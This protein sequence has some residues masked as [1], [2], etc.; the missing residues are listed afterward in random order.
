MISEHPKDQANEI[1]GKC[2]NINFA[3]RAA[4]YFL[5]SKKIALETVLATFLDVDTFFQPDFAEVLQD[6]A[7]K[8]YD[9][10]DHICYQAV[11][12]YNQ[13]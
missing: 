1:R 8:D 7:E 3:Q 5:D 4:H 9:D 2:S 10:L 12:Y 13:D 6:R 11:L